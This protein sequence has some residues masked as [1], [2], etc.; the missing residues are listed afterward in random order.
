VTANPDDR[1]DSLHQK[2]RTA[3]LPPSSKEVLVL[4]PVLNFIARISTQSESACQTVLEAGVL[5]ILLRIYV[6]FSML[7]NAA[8][9][10]ADYKEAL[11][12]ACRLTIV[13]LGQSPRHQGT[14]FNHP[15]CILWTDCHSQPPGYAVEAPAEDRGVAWRRV[16][17]LYVQRREIAIYRGSL[18]R[19]NNDTVRNIEVCAD[20]VGFT[21]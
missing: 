11:R 1:D 8:Q 9:Q 5:D 10:D 14:V 3:M 12:G 20:I 2:D 16:N 6:I 7:S 18:W 4:A 21:K 13:I 19:L 17:R 15:V